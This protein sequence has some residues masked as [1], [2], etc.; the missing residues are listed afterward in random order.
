MNAVVQFWLSMLS[1]VA[2]IGTVGYLFV[3]FLFPDAGFVLTGTELRIGVTLLA[4]CAIGVFVWS[5]AVVETVTVDNSS[6]DQNR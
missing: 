4:L 6:L 1:L 3:S 2:S 5:V